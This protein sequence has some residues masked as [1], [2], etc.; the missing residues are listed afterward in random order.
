MSRSFV[1]SGL[2]PILFVMQNR[3]EMQNCA[4]RKCAQDE[5]LRDSRERCESTASGMQSAPR[6]ARPAKICGIQTAE[7]WP[8][9]EMARSFVL[10]K[11]R[12]ILHFDQN[13]IEMRETAGNSGRKLPGGTCVRVARL[14]PRRLVLG[15]PP[16]GSRSAV[17]RQI[18]P[19]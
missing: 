5:S 10:S 6:H 19:K 14:H 1:L 3:L 7:L 11:L 2:Q 15:N 12:H 4:L 8:R 17:R 16:R 9:V 13:R 18:C